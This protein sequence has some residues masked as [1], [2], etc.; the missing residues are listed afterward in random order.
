MA[1]FPRAG[2]PDLPEQDGPGHRDADPE[3]R[4]MTRT[5]SISGCRVNTRPGNIAFSTAKPTC[6]SSPGFSK[7]RGST[8]SSSTRSRSMSSF[9][10]TAPPPTS[11]FRKGRR[12]DRSGGEDGPGRGIRFRIRL[13]PPD[14]FG[15]DDPEGFQ[16]RETFPGP[17]GAGAG[18]APIRN[19]RF[20]TTR[21]GMRIKA[22][23][24][25]SRRCVCRK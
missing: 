7:R 4:G 25:S 3:G 15:K 9:S 2:L 1:P 8:T 19:W 23:E 14:P 13:F 22:G 10:R 16:L 18:R 20:T 6:S 12:P 11:R 21:A 17:D 5:A 24:R